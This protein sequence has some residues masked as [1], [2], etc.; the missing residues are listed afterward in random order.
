MS[1]LRGVTLALGGGLLA[2]L[3]AAGAGLAQQRAESG[4]SPAAGAAG[5][6]GEAVAEGAEEMLPEFDLDALVEEALAQP[7]GTAEAGAMLRALDKLSGEVVEFDL[8]PGQ[9]K[10]L[11]RI[12]VSLGEC[13]Y[14]LDDPAGDAAGFLTVRIAADGQVIFRGWMLASSPALNALD[15]RRYDVW[16][17]RCITE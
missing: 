9:T 11:G 8:A 17:L 5:G 6:G 12:Q 14:P 7:A 4:T 2:A 13:R 16:L 15:H 3:L 10:Q 1:A